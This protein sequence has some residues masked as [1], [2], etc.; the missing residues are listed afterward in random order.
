MLDNNKNIMSGIV[1]LIID[2]VKLI[3]VI[4]FVGVMLL[5]FYFYWD[6]LDLKYVI[7]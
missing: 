3:F 6:N 1:K 2:I 7:M 4:E 5:V